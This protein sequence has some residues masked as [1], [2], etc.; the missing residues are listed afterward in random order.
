MRGSW[1]V[2]RRKN[3]NFCQKLE[4]E[5]HTNTTNMQKYAAPLCW[6]CHGASLLQV[7]VG[8]TRM[9]AT[10]RRLRPFCSCTLSGPSVAEAMEAGSL[11]ALDEDQADM[12]NPSELRLYRH[13]QD[14]RLLTQD[15]LGPGLSQF[16]WWYSWLTPDIKCCRFEEES[17]TRRSSEAARRGDEWNLWHE[18][19]WRD[20][21]LNNPRTTQSRIIIL[22]YPRAGLYKSGQFFLT[23]PGICKSRAYITKVVHDRRTLERFE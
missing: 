12:L 2:T 16:I 17:R 1:Q 14:H 19:L 10:P 11:P 18:Y 5:V 23:Y 7:G 21:P 4:Y 6:W 9:A 15:I 3:A 22:T 20:I 13:S 8:L